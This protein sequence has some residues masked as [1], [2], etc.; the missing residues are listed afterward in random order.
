M[1]IALTIKVLCL[2]STIYIYLSLHSFK[3][4]SHF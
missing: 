3:F 4:I 2:F 1:S